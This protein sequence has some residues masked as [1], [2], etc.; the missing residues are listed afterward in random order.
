[1][2]VIL[3]WWRHHCGC[4]GSAGDGRRPRAIVA[5]DQSDLNQGKGGLGEGLLLNGIGRALP[6]LGPRGQSGW[7]TSERFDGATWARPAAKLL[8]GLGAVANADIVL[9]GGVVR[10]LGN[11]ESHDR[12]GAASSK[13][14]SRA[15][16]AEKAANRWGS[17]ARQTKV[18]IASCT[19]A[20]KHRSLAHPPRKRM[21]AIS[22]PFK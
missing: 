20:P 15:T 14:G 16:A 8:H 18:A 6:G 13:G 9:R 22:Q 19:Y 1:M 2:Q 17:E 7:V 5:Q 3:M 10:E 21:A 4:R 12:E 11:T